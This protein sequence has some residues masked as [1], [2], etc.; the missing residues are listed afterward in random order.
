MIV[1]L[2]I[3]R[4]RKLFIPFALLAMAVHRIPMLMQKKS[5]FWKLLGSGRN[6]TFSLNPDLQQWG[7]LAVWDRQEDFDRFYNSSFIAT[8]WK[9]LAKEQWTI[10]CAPLQSHGKWNGKEPFGK[11]NEEIP[12]GPVAILTRATIR[13]NRLKNFWVH[14]EGTSELMSRSPG[15]IMSLGIGEARKALC[16]WLKRAC[17]SN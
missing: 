16:L 2:T 14:V 7:L 1:S 13:S 8:W 9:T 11:V 12:V 17:R 15:Y 6:S 5:T 10:L 3:T 4:Y